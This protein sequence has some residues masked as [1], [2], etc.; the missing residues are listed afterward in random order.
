MHTVIR[1]FSCDGSCW[2]VETIQEPDHPTALMGFEKI[3]A[4]AIAKYAA[5]QLD[6]LDADVT[7]IMQPCEEVLFESNERTREKAKSDD[8]HS[9]SALFEE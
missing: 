5:R 7:V 1:V 3:E 6:R 2:H 4:E 9:L 8:V